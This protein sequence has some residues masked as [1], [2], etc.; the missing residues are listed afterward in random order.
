MKDPVEE[1]CPYCGQLIVV[2]RHGRL[3]K[4]YKQPR[5]SDQPSC[6]G[7]GEPASGANGTDT[8]GVR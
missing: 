4:H 3:A 7:S 1:P 2:T 5:Y 6:L 8:S